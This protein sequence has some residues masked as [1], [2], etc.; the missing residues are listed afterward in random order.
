VIS[1]GLAALSEVVEQKGTRQSDGVNFYVWRFLWLAITGTLL[2]IVVSVIRGQFNLLLSTIN[3]GLHYLPWIALTMLFVFLGIGMKLVAKKHDAV[4]VVLIVYSIQMV[5]AYPI[6]LVGNA[7]LPGVFG[8]IPMGVWI[9]V[10]RSAGAALM[11]WG[12]IRLRKNN[13]G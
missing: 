10:I 4:S 1:N 6:T 11:I 5:L 3:S 13:S 12:V 9:W 7:I 2:A 8:Q